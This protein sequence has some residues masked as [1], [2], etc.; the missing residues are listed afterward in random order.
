MFFI[1]NI[2]SFVSHFSGEV[3]VRTIFTVSFVVLHLSVVLVPIRV[4]HCSLQELVVFEATF[5]FCIIG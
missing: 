3:Y 5:E 2:G 1:V 4:F